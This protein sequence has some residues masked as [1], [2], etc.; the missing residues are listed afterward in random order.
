[1]YELLAQVSEVLGLAAP[2][3]RTAGASERCGSRRS[4]G[5]MLAALPYI[6][7]GVGAWTALSSVVIY[8]RDRTGN[9]GRDTHHASNPRIDGPDDLIRYDRR[10]TEE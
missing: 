7:M 2:A 10:A 8:L 3:P 4:G 9:S 5:V 1:M 6:L